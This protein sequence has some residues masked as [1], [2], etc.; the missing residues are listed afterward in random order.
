MNECKAGLGALSVASGEDVLILFVVF[1]TG[2]CFGV[3][4]W[5]QKWQDLA[6]EVD[7]WRRLAAECG[8]SGGGGGSLGSYA[9]L[10]LSCS[11]RPATSEQARRILRL[12]PLP[13]VLSA[14]C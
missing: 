7:G 1:F 14:T 6:V 5:S 9:K 10:W 11:A 8:T 4:F 2:F 12:R 3:D 13:P